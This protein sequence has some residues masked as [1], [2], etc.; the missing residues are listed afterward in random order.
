METVMQQQPDDQPSTDTAAGSTR[1]EFI[2]TTAAAGVAAAAA[3]FAMTGGVYAQGSDQIK[4]GL[5]G[6]G[7]RGSGAALNALNGDPSAKIHAMGDMFADKLEGSLQR[8]KNEKGARI[9]V[10]DRK[11]SGFDA[12][13][14]VIAESDVVLL[15][16]PPHF[17]PIHLAAALDANKHCFVEKPVGVDVPSVKK[18]ME[19]CELAKQKKL[20]VVSGLCYRYDEAKGD[21]IKR[22]HDGAVGDI[23]SLQGM[24]NTGGLW[25]APRQKEWSD[26]EWQLRNWLYF[27]WLSGDHIV[28]Q[29]VHTLDK[30]L[31]I[32]KDVPPMKC[33]G[34]GG[35]TQRTG[36]D[37]GHIYDHFDTV[38]EWEVNDRP[39]RAFCQTRQWVNCD[40]DVSDWVF[41]TKG[42]ADIM[43][44]KITGEN[45][46]KRK[47]S[48]ENMYDSEHKALFA[49][50]RKGEV[51]NNGD[52][53]CKAT[54]MGI[55]G[56]MAAYTGKTI[57]WDK[58]AAKADKKANAPT[59]ME[60]TESLAPAKYEMGPLPTPPV[61]VPGSS[62]VA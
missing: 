33:T 9:D 54:L 36:A 60:N 55:M 38:F 61:A 24:Y 42:T 10:G 59:L 17:R 37:Y 23:I 19:L 7:G 29:H 27:T 46:F 28:E 30:M 34:N 25:V 35:R 50:I 18:V 53:M 44:H 31:W 4:V 58:A 45:K 21:M 8:L 14:G 22:V 48:K 41:G 13:K 39:V 43:N 62:K 57:Y 26:M 52:Y 49:A 15:A 47:E 3:N 51:I 2:R 12:Y 20:N 6:C 32:M 56:R 11:F 16:T 1:R 5:I 40:T